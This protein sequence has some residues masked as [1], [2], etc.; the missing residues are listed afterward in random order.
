MIWMVPGLC[1]SSSY[2]CDSVF[3]VTLVLNLLSFEKNCDHF[4]EKQEQTKDLLSTNRMYF[5]LSLYDHC[6]IEKHSS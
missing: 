5:P 3:V 1:S 2:L 6:G 4:M